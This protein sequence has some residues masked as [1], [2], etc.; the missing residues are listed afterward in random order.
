MPTARPSS[1][2]SKPF[3]RLLC[4]LLIASMLACCGGTP[5]ASESSLSGGDPVSGSP[6]SD[7]SG[8]E[9]ESALSEDPD[10]SS[11]PDPEPDFWDR[12]GQSRLPE[13]WTAPDY[14]TPLEEGSPLY[15]TGLHLSLGAEAMYPNG[16]YLHLF[17][18]E[19]SQYRLVNLL[20]GSETQS[21]A[22]DPQLL[23]TAGKDGIL[24]SV[25]PFTMEVRA[26]RPDGTVLVLRN[27]EEADPDTPSGYP[28]V[29]EDGH[30]LLCYDQE[31][32]IIRMEDLETGSAVF[33][34]S[35]TGISSIEYCDRESVCL[36][37]W[38]RT[39]LRLYLSGE[40]TAG[41]EPDSNDRT[42][43]SSGFRFYSRHG[44]GETM[45][46]F[47]ALPGNDGC[48]SAVVPEP[49]AS[50]WTLACGILGMT[51]SN[52]D[53]PYL[54]ADLRTGSCLK[55]CAIPNLEYINS[56]TVSEEGFAL[57]SASVGEGDLSIF[58]YD[59][60]GADP[61]GTLQT[62]ELAEEDMRLK[63]DDFLE[64]LRAEDG[65]EIFYG[66]E[67]NDF[68]IGDYV[69]EV[70][71]NPDLAY[72]NIQMLSRT[73]ALYPEGMLREA[74]EGADG[75]EGIQLYLCGTL[76]GTSEYGLSFAS[77]VTSS[78]GSRIII[79]FDCT[80][81]YWTQDI[82]HEFSHLFDRRI[83]TVSLETGVDWIEKFESLSPRPYA[84]TYQDYGK[85]IKYTN[86]GSSDPSEIWYIDCYSRTFS[87][88]DRAR[89]IEYLFRTEEGG[90]HHYL[91]PEHI[92]YKAKAYCYI[93]RKCFSSLSG[94][95]AYWERYLDLSGFTLE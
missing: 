28:I 91:Q 62:E 42:E 23:Y 73:L 38:N 54:F 19:S 33:F 43:V 20:T 53:L 89:L 40:S 45:F 24:Y 88:E 77:A 31:S 82:P 72:V 22:F 66:S 75:Y 64:R 55:P 13:T 46:L 3:G 5:P 25:S 21:F 47:R 70:L 41:K 81:E 56:L 68:L 83:S 7:P 6:S 36:L 2:R 84:N 78:N 49:E 51:T 65:I 80:S 30:F 8:S 37:M 85:L 48:F 12:N 95:T 67:G 27:A 16:H 87:T 76:Y 57:I 93:L 10:I 35:P 18:Y 26:F 59:L 74:W 61:A 32:R 14:C 17:N 39:P 29:S 44:F 11:D 52:A 86:D 15:D 71:K 92:Q 9:S 60:T 58:L 79:A 63:T 69:G 90:M 50:H 94:K 34:P 4:L 1:R